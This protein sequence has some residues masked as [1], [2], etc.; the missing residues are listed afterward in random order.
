MRGS[1]G[2]HV[3]AGGPGWVVR[4][5]GMCEEG[6]RVGRTSGGTRKALGNRVG[7]QGSTQ[8]LRGMRVHARQ[9]QGHR[10]VLRVSTCMHARRSSV[11]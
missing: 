6:K 11:T 1:Y 7:R 3:W 2:G 9:A 10:S 5:E 4:V 8:T